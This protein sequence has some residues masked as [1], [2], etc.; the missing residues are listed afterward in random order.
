MTETLSTPARPDPAQLDPSVRPGDHGRF[1]PYGG[2]YVPETLM[3]AL[4][5]LEKAA[6]EAWKDH[7]F[8]T[9]LDRLLRTYVGRQTPLYEAE[10]LSAYYRRAE[11][12]PRIWLKRE[13]A[14]NL[15]IVTC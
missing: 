7:S 4:A 14:L 8:T 2:Q 9:Q 12:G 10:R 15:T 1:G 6:S 5:E 13:S 3:P 11:G